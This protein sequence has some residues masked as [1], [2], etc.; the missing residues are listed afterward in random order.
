MIIGPIILCTVVTGIAGVQDMKQVGKVGS[1]AL[2]YFEVVSTMALFIGLIA[3][4]VFT[5][6]SGMNV[7]PADLDKSAIT[8][9]TSK[10]HDTTSRAHYLVHSQ[11]EIF[12]KFCW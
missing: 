12:F 11:R 1:K 8:L 7:N 3:A 2:I 10:A 4:Y 9:Y 5:S 6:G